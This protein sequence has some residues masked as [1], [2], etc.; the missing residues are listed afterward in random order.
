MDPFEDTRLRSEELLWAFTLDVLLLKRVCVLAW[1]P[2]Y[3]N[4]VNASL[5]FFFF[6]FSRFRSNR[7][8]FSRICWL[9]HCKQC[10]CALFTDLQIPLFIIFSLK[11]GLTV[12]F[13]HLK[14]ISLQYF[15]FQFS[16]SV[17][18]SSIQTDPKYKYDRFV[19]K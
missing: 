16:V 14:N 4:T 18:I 2:R 3:S 1:D 8:L 15:Q 7:L 9:F 11:M 6:V 12:L 10:I 13:T 5:F 19:G 17:K